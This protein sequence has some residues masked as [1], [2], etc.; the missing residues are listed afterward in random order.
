MFLIL[1]R[2]FSGSAARLM[3]RQGGNFSVVTVGSL[4]DRSN[5]NI[6]FG[7][8]YSLSL[9]LELLSVRFYG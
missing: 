1:R 7:D 4:G 3:Q 9:S 8:F 2:G 6:H 5:N